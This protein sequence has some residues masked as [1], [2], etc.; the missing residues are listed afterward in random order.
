MLRPSALRNADAAGAMPSPRRLTAA[1]GAAVV[2]CLAA[3]VAAIGPAHPERATY[4]WPP[5]VAGAAPKTGWYTPLPLL[6]RVPGSVEVTLPCDL[7]PPLDQGKPATVLAT[8]RDPRAAGALAMEEAGGSLRIAVGSSRIATLPWPGTCPLPIGVAA[9]QLRLPNRTIELHGAALDRMPIVTSLFTTLD[10]RKGERP[11]VSISTRAYATSSTARQAIAEAFAAAFAILALIL[12]LRVRFRLRS[13]G[14]AI[15]VAWR[16][17][18]AVDLVVLVAL[19]CWWILAPT[20]YD[21]G[22]EGMSHRVFGDIGTMNVYI[23]IWG[24][25][26][27]SGYWLEW[28][29]HWVSGSSTVLIV[30]RVPTLICLATIWWLCRV[31][32]RRVAG[33]ESASGA[34]WTL[35]A[36]FLVGVTAW[37]MTLRPE[38]IMALLA[39]LVLAAMVAFDASRPLSALTVACL[40]AVFALTAHPTGLIAAAPLLASVALVPRIVRQGRAGILTLGFT[41][42]I[43]AVIGLVLFTLHSD[44]S[45]R[46]EDARIVRESD[47]HSYPVWQEFVRY[48]NFDSNGGATAPRH[49]SLALL[50][51]VALLALTRRTSANTGIST[52]PARSVLVALLLLAVVPSKW[53]WHFGA[54][55]PLCAVGLA[56]EIEHLIRSP[57]TRATHLRRLG[58]IG[59]LAVVALWSWRAPGTWGPFDLE[60]LEWNDGFG[61]KGYG[62][63]VLAVLGVA[64]VGARALR[65]QRVSIRVPSSAAMVGW[66]VPVIS[67]AVI[68]T[69][70]ALL[71]LDALVS[72]WSPARQNLA[73]L[74]DRAGC[75]LADQLKGSDDAK[76]AVREG[77]PPVLLSPATDFYFPCAAIPRIGKGVIQLPTYVAIEPG[78]TS[79]FLVLDHDAPFAALADLGHFQPVADGPHGVTIYRVVDRNAG[80]E[81]VDPTRS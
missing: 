69:T 63:P 79:T 37:G 18:E 39:A 15:R 77:A 14:R 36:A 58:L 50:L 75:G 64:V 19:V 2:A 16:A 20:F 30:A 56:A 35:A 66:S 1:L 11:R 60:T 48:Q 33:D 54:L 4:V 62:L 72:P 12:A 73:A 59:V 41:A 71:F 42:L 57:S 80:F 17:R 5:Q 3:F 8:A 46:S 29:R 32:F 26:W 43:S 10:L 34:R 52:L 25:N 44:L 7:S 70:M 55:I 65:R 61:I 24:V 81:R 6:N 31:C 68:S 78:S 45:H 51:L 49:L 9:G 23:D 74:V 21:D 22:W 28:L 40:A 76:R 13:A 53:P 27:P 47:L 38:P 67:A